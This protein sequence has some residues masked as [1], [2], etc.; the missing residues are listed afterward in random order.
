MFVCYQ[1]VLLNVLRLILGGGVLFAETERCNIVVFENATCV[2]LR[3]VH[4]GVISVALVFLEV[5]FS[6]RCQVRSQTV[7]L[8][9]L[10]FFVC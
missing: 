10:S 9:D 4:N 5:F 2:R 3:S 1:I 7:H 6:H 8:G